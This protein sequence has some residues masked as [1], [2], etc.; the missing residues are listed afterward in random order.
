MVEYCIIGNNKYMY[1]H[2]IYTKAN[3][4]RHT[5]A[6]VYY[7]M[8]AH[9]HTPHAHTQT[10]VHTC[11]CMHTCTHILTQHTISYVYTYTPKP[12]IEAIPTILPD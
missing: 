9:M 12:I 11:T 4:H 6:H 3:T 1:I 10:C 7:I 8:H 5:H 2:R